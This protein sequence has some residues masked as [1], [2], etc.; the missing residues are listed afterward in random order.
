MR[1]RRVLAG[2][3]ASSA[4]LLGSELMTVGFG[5]AVGNELSIDSTVPLPEPGGPLLLLSGTA[6]LFARRAFP[7]PR[8]A[9]C[10]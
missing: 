10:A 7:R 2:A 9:L 6:A 4:F 5:T 3:A 1:P 8:R